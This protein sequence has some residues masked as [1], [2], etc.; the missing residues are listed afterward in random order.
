MIDDMRASMREYLVHRVLPTL[1]SRDLRLQYRSL[2]HP[3]T[4]VSQVILTIVQ[5]GLIK[6]KCE[7][8]AT[9]VP[10]MDHQG[11]RPDFGHP[12]PAPS[13][14]LPVHTPLSY[15]SAGD[16]SAPPPSP[17]A[18]VPDSTAGVTAAAAS[19]TL[20]AVAD[21]IAYAEAYD[22]GANTIIPKD[23]R[24]EVSVSIPS[25]LIMLTFNRR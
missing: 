8:S 18:T 15:F 16:A 6:T 23:S 24:Y 5:P 17:A 3:P 4:L 19:P 25:L 10:T 20:S 11:Y 7:R 12:T 1:V 14:N 21:A 2:L 22:D 13:D 9:S